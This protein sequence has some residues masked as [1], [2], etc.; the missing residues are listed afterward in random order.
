VWIPPG[1]EAAFLAPLAVRKIPG[2]GKVTEQK[3]HRLGI[4]QVGDLAALDAKF[5]AEHLG[6][7]GL[8]LAGKSKGL[9]A[10]GWF[11]G[12]IGAEQNPKSISHEHTFSVD[13]ADSE[14]LEAALAHLSEKVGRRLREH[15]LWARTIQLKL[16]YS[17]FSTFTRALTLG[18]ATQIDT[19]IYQTARELLRKNRRAGAAIRLLGVQTSGLSPEAGQLDLLEGAQQERMGRALSAMDK[20]RDKYGEGSVSLALG[21]QG[22]FKE[23]T[24]EALPNAPDQTGKPKK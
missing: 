8:A 1:A 15:G 10:G 21:L 23:R 22:R 9:D 6:E 3:L 18:H 5:L 24:H 2:V 13:T 12:E 16:R 11:Q 17:D 14:A 4:R 19:E 20:L 7:W